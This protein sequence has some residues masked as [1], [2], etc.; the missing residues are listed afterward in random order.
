MI[1]AEL[2]PDGVWEH[3]VLGHVDFMD[4]IQCQR[5]NVKMKQIAERLLD[6]AA[7][8]SIV[9]GREGHVEDEH[10]VRPS[11]TLDWRRVRWDITSVPS[12]GWGKVVWAGQWDKRAFAATLAVGSDGS[13]LFELRHGHWER[14]ECSHSLLAVTDRSVIVAGR[15]DGRTP[16]Y[17]LDLASRTWTRLPDLSGR[18]ERGVG[19]VV[20]GGDIV[21]M[22]GLEHEDPRPQLYSPRTR[23]WRSL[24]PMR[25]RRRWFRAVVLSRSEILV[26]G[27]VAHEENGVILS[28]CERLDL[29]TET[30]HAFP[31]MPTSRR[32]F[33]VWNVHGILVVA[34]GFRSRV[35]DEVGDFAFDD[36]I[37]RFGRASK[38]VHVC[39]LSSKPPHWTTVRALMLPSHRT[40]AG[41]ALLVR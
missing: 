24:P 6:G 8:P 21:V 15:C 39:R 7:R 1:V 13:D 5:V 31:D 23:T 22:G 16:V 29:A 40:N 14:V 41:S 4:W 27:G 35:D 37:W 34:G 2:L 11:L 33:C 12:L 28:S 30:W 19:L 9:G 38:T 25:T 18:Y 10:V 36:G 32:N 20:P 3:H 17:E 26:L